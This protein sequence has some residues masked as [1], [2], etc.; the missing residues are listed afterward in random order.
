MARV[1][2]IG[3]IALVALLALLY[4]RPRRD[5]DSEQ[6]ALL[7]RELALR[8][9]MVAA[10]VGA[11]DGKFAFLLARKFDGA[12]SM[13]VTE[14]DPKLVASMQGRRPPNVTVLEGA[15]GNARL[16]AAC[17]DVV[18]L[19]RV[20]HHFT[21][22]G[23]MNASLFRAIRPGGTIAVIDRPAGLSF[24][25]IS[26]QLRGPRNRWGHGI[27]IASVSDELRAAGFQVARVISWPDRN[28][29]VIGKKPKT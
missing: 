9:G 25:L 21:E 1:I 10:E 24:N 27:S 26:F 14:L 22:P 3:L 19:R 2:L 5:T 8:P 11:G 29:C 15:A 17:C 16:P 28:Y 20:F 23:S 7:A 6:V 12:L 18:Y 13:Y 4:F